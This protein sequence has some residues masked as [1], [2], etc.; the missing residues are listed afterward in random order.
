MA[1]RLQATLLNLQDD[2]AKMREDREFF[3]ELYVFRNDDSRAPTWLRTT[4]RCHSW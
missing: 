3:R 4:T 2:M 1:E